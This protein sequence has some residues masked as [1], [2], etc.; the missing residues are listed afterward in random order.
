MYF[1]FRSFSII[2][3]EFISS[4]QPVKQSPLTSL[5]KFSVMSVD[6]YFDQPYYRHY[7]EGQ[8]IVQRE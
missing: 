1:R 2:K 4:T 6:L 5:L 7:H 3:I 8:S